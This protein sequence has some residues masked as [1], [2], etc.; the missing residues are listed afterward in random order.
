MPRR[1]FE[2]KVIEGFI[3]FVWYFRI[4]RADPFLYQRFQTVEYFCCVLYMKTL[5]VFIQGNIN[6]TIRITKS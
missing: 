5:N 1:C 6:S 4:D 2:C 3:S